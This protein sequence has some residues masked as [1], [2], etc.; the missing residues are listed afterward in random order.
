MLVPLTRYRVLRHAV[1]QAALALALCGNACGLGTF[2]GRDE[3]DW[4]E[5]KVAVVLALVQETGPS[6]NG[7]EYEATFLPRS[8]VA[9]N[10]DCGLHP[11]L[12][13]RFFASE[14]GGTSIKSPPRDG[15]LVMAVI[16]TKGEGGGYDVYAEYCAF[17]PGD[18]AMLPVRGIDDRRV[19]ETLK[20]IQDLRLKPKPAA[21]EPTTRP[22]TGRSK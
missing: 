20:R 6:A 4:A 18:E 22:A 13:M 15:D 8:T 19:A 9:G 21:G 10:F 3:S 7:Y 12:R 16:G 2:F 1:I 11:R 14:T 5:G 17:M